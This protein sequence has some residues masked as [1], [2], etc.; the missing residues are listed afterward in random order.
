AFAALLPSAVLGTLTVL[1]IY[2]VATEIMRQ[3]GHT[4]GRAVGLL[5]A[6]LAATSRWH[7]SLSRSG[8]EVVL[9]PLL[10]CLAVYAL[11]VALRIGT[12]EPAPHLVPEAQPRPA[13]ASSRKRSRHRRHQVAHMQVLVPDPRLER[14]RLLL[15][16]LC[17]IC[18]GLASDLAPGLW[19]V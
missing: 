1:L 4:R 18:T 9:L 7:V 11:L 6:L 16:A 5:A 15:F 14:R 3:G 12:P 8:T 13:A 2:L 17:G 10:L 19:L